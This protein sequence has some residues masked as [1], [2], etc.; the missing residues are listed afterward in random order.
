MACKLPME[1]APRD[2]AQN[3]QKT[4]RK[5]IEWLHHKDDISILSSTSI[6]SASATESSPLGPL[7][8]EVF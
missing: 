6:A 4:Q 8:M 5:K 1:N 3:F 7:K 2:V